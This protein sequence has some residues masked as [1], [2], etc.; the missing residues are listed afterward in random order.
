MHN[1]KHQK[2][3]L[4]WGSFLLCQFI[5][6]PLIV[7]QLIGLEALVKFMPEIAQNKEWILLVIVI[8]WLVLT[9]TTIV[10]GRKMGPLVMRRFYTREE[11]YEILAGPLGPRPLTPR[12]E[13]SINRQLE[14]L[15]K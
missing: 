8:P 3:K 15:Y 11:M 10:L 7:L 6:I 1:S 9:R 2:G 4:M 12:R 14:Y 5:G 13:I